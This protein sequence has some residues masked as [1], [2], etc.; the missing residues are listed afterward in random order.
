[1]CASLYGQIPATDYFDKAKARDKHLKTLRSVS[2][3]YRRSVVLGIKHEA[4]RLSLSL[5]EPN[6]SA[7]QE[8]RR[9]RTPVPVETPYG[10]DWRY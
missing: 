9:S 5:C 8:R 4:A 2:R 6:V 3:A 7:E 1:M 10:W